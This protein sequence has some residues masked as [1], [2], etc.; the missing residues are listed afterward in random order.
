MK[1]LVVSPAF[2]PESFRINDVVLH[3]VAHG[4]QVEVLAG[5]PHYPVGQF[6]PG[7]TWLGPFVDQYEGA[8]VL[9]FP[10][11]P[12]GKGRKWELL[13]QYVSFV[14][15][16]TLRVLLAGRFDWDAVFVFQS[17]PV[18]VALPGLFA[19][20]LAGARRIIWVQ[21]LW[22]EVMDDAGVQIPKGL[23]GPI[24]WLSHSIYRA[25]DRVLTQNESMI[26][27]LEE[28]GVEKSRMANVYNWADACFDQPWRRLPERTTFT[29]MVAGN[30]GRVQAIPTVL[31][32]AKLLR[33]EP[34]IRWI[35]LGDGPMAGSSRELIE[36]WGLGHC[37]EMPGSRP[38][39][40]MPAWYERADAMLVSLNSGEALER[41]VP[42]R[43]Q[44]YLASRRPIIVSGNGEAARL[45][46]L[47]GA[48]V[49]APAED[50]KALAEQVMSL[51][52]LP[53]E[54][55]ERMASAGL[56]FYKSH[57][58]M[59][60]CMDRIEAEISGAS[61]VKPLGTFNSGQ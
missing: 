12:R 53:I 11:F 47:A 9:R 32:A 22:P 42:S 27:V 2:W 25:F 38:P 20:S 60:A 45:V 33:D 10:Q 34:Q 46:T 31:G 4:H 7:F 15:L 30:L 40:E 23:L 36:Q 51:S 8:T 21:D 49:A 52:R 16:G 48:G 18:T 28:A 50:A 58:S 26:P 14:T 5:H 55:R 57:F 13:C 6:F 54:E 17:S 37:V 43:L 3:L 59:Q 24:R 35:L 29:V 56:A 41:T 19:S 1:V 44:G 39:S 61:V